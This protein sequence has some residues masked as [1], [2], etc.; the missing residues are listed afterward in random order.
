VLEERAEEIGAEW[1]NREWSD[2]PGNP[3]LPVVENDWD[4]VRTR[5]A[6]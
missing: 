5:L 4:A 3:E 6:R 2:G 1:R